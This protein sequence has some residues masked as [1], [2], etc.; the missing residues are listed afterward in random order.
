MVNYT[1]TVYTS[2]ADVKTAVDAI[3]NTAT[4]EVLSFK[5]GGKQKFMVIT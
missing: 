3:V 4:I 5:E 2:S 1:A